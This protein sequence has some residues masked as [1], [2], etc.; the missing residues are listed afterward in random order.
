[1]LGHVIVFISDPTSPRCRYVAACRISERIES[2]V[3]VV[4][5]RMRSRSA[6][7]RGFSAASSNRPQRTTNS[8]L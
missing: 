5:V 7:N 6:C 8:S 3:V 1:V 4:I 2:C